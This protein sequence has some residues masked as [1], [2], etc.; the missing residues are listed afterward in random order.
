[1]KKLIPLAALALAA[2]ST[3]APVVGQFTSTKDEFMGQATASWTA[4]TM[5]IQSQAGI[6]CT[7]ALRRDSTVNGNGDLI[8][9]DGRTGTFVFTKSNEYGGSGFGTLSNGE[10]FRFLWGN[11]VGR[12]ARCDQDPDGIACTRI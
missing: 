3:T 4:G 8:C 1:M 9:S 10:K 12:R 2:C 11:T 5:S 6:T 7:G